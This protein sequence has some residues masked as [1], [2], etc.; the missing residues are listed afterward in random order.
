MIEFHGIRGVLLDIEGTTTPIDFVHQTLFPYATKHLDTY[1]NRSFDSSDRESLR[2]DY[3]LETASDVPRWS[4]PPVEYL[5]W[6]MV[7]DRK[8]RG[9]KSIQGK[10]W[11]S[12][13]KSGELVGAVYPDVAPAFR[14]WEAA[15]KS[16]NIYSSGSVQAQRLIFGYSTAGEL[17]PFI[18]GYFDTTTGPKRESSSYQSIS[19]V[20]G[21][22]AASILFISD[23]P[24]ELEAARGAG[25]QVCLSIRPENSVQDWDGMSIRSFDE[26]ELP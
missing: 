5:Q 24:A 12:G 7:Q 19:A 23:I 18:G 25:L 13:Y 8:S 2:A 3:E 6:L 22:P 20:L 4:E 14:H 21:M 9:L 10:I 17:T 26:L 1:L 15:G 11:E 16:I